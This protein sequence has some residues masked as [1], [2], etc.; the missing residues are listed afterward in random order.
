MPPHASLLNR[1]VA[2]RGGRAFTLIELLVVIAIIG[3]L[4][5]SA[6][7]A[8]RGLT[9]ANTVASGSRQ[10]LD[11][12]AYARQLAISSRR[13]VYMVF[14]PPTIQ[15]HQAELQRVKPPERQRQ[16]LRQ[17][18][19]LVGAPYTTYALFSWRT[20]GDQPGRKTP[21]YLTE[22]RQLPEGMFLATNRFEDLGDV[23]WKAATNQATAM[24]NLPL[25]QAWFPFPASDAP[26]LRM[27]YLAFDPAGRVTYEGFNRQAA[28][29]IP[30]ASVTLS[31]GS[32]MPMRDTQGRPL[33]PDV[34][35]TPRGNRTDMV[36]HPLTGRARVV[37]LKLP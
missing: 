32:V 12:L 33:P 5:V 30:E 37:E 10:M 19:N 25:P 28:F 3:I 1:P 4:A 31:R 36:I 29:R 14:V 15:S 22:W 7:P 23:W 18:T 16:L 8:I 9:S 20:V 2:D 17:Y 26:P 24:T 6:V 27:P 11:D 21:R 13:T 35:A 34:V